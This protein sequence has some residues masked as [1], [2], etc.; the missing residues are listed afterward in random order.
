M[1]A[2]RT[3]LMLH[4]NHLYKIK[5]YHFHD[6][7]CCNTTLD[8]LLDGDRDKEGTSTSEVQNIIRGLLYLSQRNQILKTVCSENYVVTFKRKPWKISQ[9]INFKKNGKALKVCPFLFEVS[10][11]CKKSYFNKQECNPERSPLEQKNSA[12][13]TNTTRKCKTRSSSRNESRQPHDELNARKDDPK[14]QNETKCSSA[15]RKR[16]RLLKSL[17]SRRKKL[18][19]KRRPNSC[20]KVVPVMSCDQDETSSSSENEE[21]ES[22]EQSEEE[23]HQS[24]KRKAAKKCQSGGDWADKTKI[25]VESPD[26]RL[27]TSGDIPLNVLTKMS[28]NKRRKENESILLD[29]TCTKKVDLTMQGGKSFHA[30]VDIIEEEDDVQVAD[31]LGTSSKKSKKKHAT[32]KDN[33]SVLEQ[34]SRRKRCLN[35]YKVADTPLMNLPSLENSLNEPSSNLTQQLNFKHTFLSP[36]GESSVES[37]EGWKNAHSSLTPLSRFNRSEPE[38]GA[39]GRNKRSVNFPV[40]DRHLIERE[41]IAEDIKL[42]EMSKADSSLR[43]SKTERLSFGKSLWETLDTYFISPVKMMFDGK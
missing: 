2:C 31:I 33:V 14:T 16:K 18:L 35:L 26:T 27:N 11:T 8:R 4:V 34:S 22:E 12:E 21:D 9:K 13:S 1:D 42:Q 3:K 25:V 23:Y 6:A 40:K 43:S 39:N 37:K 29:K 5:F 41:E 28:A 10:F 30:T 15:I 7:D 38:K 17:P 19:V 20:E 36:G 32:D 24:K